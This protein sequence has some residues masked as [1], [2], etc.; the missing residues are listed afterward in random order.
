MFALSDREIGNLYKS[1]KKVL[2]NNG[3]ILTVVTLLNAAEPGE[4]DVFGGKLLSQVK[5]L[6]R[7][8][9]VIVSP[10]NHSQFWGWQRDD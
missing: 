8:L 7:A 4:K 5:C 10:N 3:Q 1:I 2:H 9:L 6:V